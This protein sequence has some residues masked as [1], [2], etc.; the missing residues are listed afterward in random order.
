MS[1]CLAVEWLSSRGNSLCQPS[2]RVFYS[3]AAPIPPFGKETPLESTAPPN[4]GHRSFSYSALVC[5]GLLWF[6]LVSGR[7]I[8]S[9]RC[10]QFWSYEDCILIG[11]KPQ[12]HRGDVE[13]Y[14]TTNLGKISEET[15]WDSTCIGQ[16]F[17]KKYDPNCQISQI[18][19]HMYSNYI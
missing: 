8:M 7:P 6:A 11:P 17:F 2:I 5:F 3:P 1:E 19:W 18:A 13:T 16:R 4:S 9:Y 14:K 10:E 12:Q 15:A